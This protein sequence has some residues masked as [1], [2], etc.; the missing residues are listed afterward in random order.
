METITKYY[1]NKLKHNSD[2]Y[3]SKHV[4]DISDKYLALTLFLAGHV[5]QAFI[6]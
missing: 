2:V 4:I 3:Q 6:S 1:A 5:S